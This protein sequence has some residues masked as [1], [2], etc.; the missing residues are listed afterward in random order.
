MFGVEGKCGIEKRVSKKD[1]GRRMGRKE[2][3]AL[4]KPLIMGEMCEVA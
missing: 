1:K 3:V 2:L 4:L